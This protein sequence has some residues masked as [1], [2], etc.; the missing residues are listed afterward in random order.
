MQP[1]GATNVCGLVTPA[2]LVAMNVDPAHG[3]T[4]TTPSGDGTTSGCLTSSV[5]PN[6]APNQQG[7]R[8]ILIRLFRVTLATFVD[9]NEEDKLVQTVI[10]PSIRPDVV[11]AV[12][13]IGSGADHAIFLIK[14]YPEPYAGQP[15][16][17]NFT[18]RFLRAST[19]MT[20]G[21]TT[22]A[23]ATDAAARAFLLALAQR[24]IGNLPALGP[25]PCP[26]I[27][28]AQSILDLQQA[29]RLTGA[30]DSLVR[31]DE[32]SGF[33]RRGTADVVAVLNLQVVGGL[34]QVDQGAAPADYFSSLQRALDQVT[35]AAITMGAETPHAVD[36]AR[37]VLTLQTGLS[38][39]A[40]SISF[41]DPACSGA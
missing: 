40:I 23:F 19:S 34:A 14:H 16:Y 1:T 37:A 30:I 39:L 9:P 20:L 31:A 10:L 41:N 2:D 21:V 27:V 12:P 18:L 29:Q 38:D 15:N 28:Q 5:N 3:E 24:A 8:E 32:N 4:S 25:P 13:D 26:A 35:S 22:D 6:S 17:A 7:Q 33:A 11:E 36:L